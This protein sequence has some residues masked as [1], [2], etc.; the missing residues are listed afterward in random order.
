M[1]RKSVKRHARRMT[2]FM[3]VLLVI[4]FV[5]EFVFGLWNNYFEFK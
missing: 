5:D 3:L 4:E 2:L 1:F